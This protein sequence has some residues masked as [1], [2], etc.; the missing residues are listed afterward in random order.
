MSDAI[1]NLTD[2]QADT[3]RL[4]GD[5]HVGGNLTVS[6]T[7][8]GFDAL[9]SPYATTTSMSSSLSFPDGLTVS[10]GGATITGNSSIAGGLSVSGALSGAGVTSMLA[11]YALATNVPPNFYAFSPLI[12]T[13]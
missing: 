12:G 3:I 9:L 7:T 8:S 6:G 10:G 5:V 4:E 11:P 13:L 1:S 2:I